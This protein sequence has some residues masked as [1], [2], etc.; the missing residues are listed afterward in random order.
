[1]NNTNPTKNSVILC[2][3]SSSSEESEH[4]KI[5]ESNRSS[6]NASVIDENCE[7][8]LPPAKR[9]CRKNNGSNVLPSVP[10]T[11]RS[12]YKESETWLNGSHLK[13]INLKTF[14]T[15][16]VLLFLT[17]FSGFRKL[18][19]VHILKSIMVYK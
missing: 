19:T 18:K 4:E 2:E 14:E 16:S 3:Y 9:F 17:E 8:P 13:H 7:K 5:R 15:M 12:M 6:N 10:S 11:I 1:M